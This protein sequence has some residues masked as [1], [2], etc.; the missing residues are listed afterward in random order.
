MSYTDTPRPRSNQPPRL[1][2][3][4]ATLLVILAGAVAAHADTLD[5]GG[6]RTVAVVDVEGRAYVALEDLVTALDLDQE[7]AYDTG[8]YT[9]LTA[10]LRSGLTLTFVPGDRRVAV[11]REDRYIPFPPLLHDGVVL[12]PVDPFVAILQTSSLPADGTATRRLLEVSFAPHLD[13]TRL[14]FM[15][16]APAEVVTTANPVGSDL[17]VDVR[18]A[19][20]GLPDAEIPVGTAQVGRVVFAPADRS[21]LL[22]AVLSLRCRALVE[23]F[24]LESGRR[25]IIDVIDQ[26][27]RQG[28]GVVTAEQRDF[29]GSCR[30]MLDPGHGG[31]DA[32]ASLAG[33]VPEKTWTLDLARALQAELVADAFDVELSRQA[34][35]DLPMPARINGLNGSTPDLV[36]SLHGSPAPAPDAPPVV[37]LFVLLPPAADGPL[38]DERQLYEPSAEECRS[39]SRLAALVR[40]A[41]DAQPDLRCTVVVAPRLLP[42]MRLLTP[43]V[44]IDVCAPPPTGAPA[45][46][47]RDRIVRTLR[48]GLRTFFAEAFM[49]RPAPEDE[50]PPSPGDQPP[51]DP[52]A[53]PFPPGEVPDR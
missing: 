6:G 53:P 4:L 12:L 27:L 19:V 47:L 49:E 41:F 31:A 25:I 45:L 52:G 51:M 48:D 5:L 24:S 16:S 50:L 21:G 17:R 46:A 20:L 29:H 7:Y 13:F 39:A 42:M 30:I 8:A 33:G 10:D 14:Q 44:L 23:T 1:I 9:L 36:L 26:D 28:G 11:N 40:A 2:R 32:G 35:R 37:T 18:D 22:R 43:S 34:D 38:T 15:F 3:T